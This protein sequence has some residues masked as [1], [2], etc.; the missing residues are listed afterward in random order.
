MKKIQLVCPDGL[1]GENIPLA[2]RIVAICDVYDAV[3]SDRVYK[4]GWSH[5]EAVQMIRNNRGSH[6]DP[7]ITDAF[8]LEERLF[9]ITKREYAG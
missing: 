7:V 6:F 1:A 4:K 2:A 3:T 5:E 9:E 8:M